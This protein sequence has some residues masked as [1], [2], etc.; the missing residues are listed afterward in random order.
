M[1]STVNSTKL[2]ESSVVEFSQAPAL[3]IIVDM[4]VTTRKYRNL[5]T[6][7]YVALVVGWDEDKT[8]QYEGV[9][10]ELKGKEEQK[11]RKMYFRKLPASQSFEKHGELR[12]FKIRPTWIRYSDFSA[13]PWDIWEMKL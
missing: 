5:Q 7:P 4:F 3:E 11:Y 9:A 10:S 12:F 1:L 6:N 8:L 2:P 13:K